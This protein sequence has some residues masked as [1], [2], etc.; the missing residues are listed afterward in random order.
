MIKEKKSN[1]SR[2]DGRGKRRGKNEKKKRKMK[3][4]RECRKKRE[5]S[6]GQGA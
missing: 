2:L 3:K 6:A 1:P 4:W 5:V